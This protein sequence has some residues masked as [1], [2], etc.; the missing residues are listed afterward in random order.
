MILALVSLAGRCL[1]I[2]S[3]SYCYALLGKCI[4]SYLIKMYIISWIGSDF[5]KGVILI[6]CMHK[7]S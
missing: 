7:H 4:F 6:Y 3:S 2:E 1:S 5:F